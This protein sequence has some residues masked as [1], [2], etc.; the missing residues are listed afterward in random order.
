MSK[1]KTKAVVSVFKQNRNMTAFMS[2]AGLGISGVGS[3]ADMEL[4]YETEED[5]TEERVLKA[6]RSMIQT[7]DDENHEILLTD[8]KVVSI[9]KL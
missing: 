9:T 2:A 8:P 1:H 5:V 3:H 7:M 4:S 6:V